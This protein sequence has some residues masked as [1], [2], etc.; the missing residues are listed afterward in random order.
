MR[1][2][3]VHNK[4]PEKE[5]ETR[6]SVLAADKMLEIQEFDKR[7]REMYEKKEFKKWRFCEVYVKELEEQWAGEVVS[8][9][10][11]VASD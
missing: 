6:F 5:I 2:K 7:V 11:S 10:C 9:Q 1:I 4:L 8:E 3:G